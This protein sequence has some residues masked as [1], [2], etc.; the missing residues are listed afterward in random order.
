LVKK[1]K[2]IQSFKKPAT[3]KIYISKSISDTMHLFYN[4]IRV[5]ALDNILKW[6]E[7][8]NFFRIK[9]FTGFSHTSPRQ[10]TMSITIAR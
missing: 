4:N 1:K 6:F 10:N 3:L 8:I 2:L 7:N 9:Q 5:I